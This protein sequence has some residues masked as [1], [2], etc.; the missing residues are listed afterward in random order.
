VCSWSGCKVGPPFGK[1]GQVTASEPMMN[2]E[3]LLME[4]LDDQSLCNDCKTQTNSH[5]PTLYNV[6]SPNETVHLLISLVC[7]STQFLVSKLTNPS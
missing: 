5:P 3:G 6:V 1:W 4:M 2:N 7:T